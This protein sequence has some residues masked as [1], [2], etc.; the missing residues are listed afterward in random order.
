MTDTITSNTAIGF[1]WEPGN[2]TRYDLIAGQDDT[3][4]RFLTWLHRGG[5]GGGLVAFRSPPFWTYL[6]D[7]MAGRGDALPT[8]EDAAALA[9]F[10]EALHEA[11]KD[12][13]GKLTLTPLRQL[14]GR[15]AL[16]RDPHWEDPIAANP[17]RRGFSSD[18][19]AEGYGEPCDARW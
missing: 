15:L 18:E 19:P 11:L 13:P 12:V 8:D 14:P 4:R 17:P 2:G 5:S 1:V 9:V 6:R 10:C 3:G 16:S 7:K